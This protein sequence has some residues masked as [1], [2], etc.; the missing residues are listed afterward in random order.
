M[1]SDEHILFTPDGPVRA[2]AVKR[3]E[4]R[5]RYD[6][7]IFESAKGMPWA[8]SGRVQDSAQPTRRRCIAKGLINRYGAAPHCG[9][10]SGDQVL[11]T[12]NCRERFEQLIKASEAPVARDLPVTRVPGT[13]KEP[14]LAEDPGGAQAGMSDGT[15]AAEEPRSEA[16][17]AGA[18]SSSSSS[19]EQ[20][21]SRDDVSMDTPPESSTAR[22]V[23]A[24]SIKRLRV[25]KRIRAKPSGHHAAGGSNRQARGVRRVQQR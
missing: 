17:A 2:R 10:C 16:P 1:K 19:S 6:L 4:E 8:S 3:K 18:C 11:H 21:P 24:T 7:N 22:V 25:Q 23:T 20:Q 15:V 5:D 13:S 14:P 9:D 12:A